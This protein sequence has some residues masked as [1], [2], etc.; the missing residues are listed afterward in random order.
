[1]CTDKAM[2]LVDLLQEN[3]VLRAEVASLAELLD[4]AQEIGEVPADW[5][6]LLKDARQTQKYLNI[7]EQYESL[8]KKLRDVSDKSE[9]E[10]LLEEVEPA[11]LIK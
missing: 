6:S 4:V 10:T 11:I 2:S 7:A 8:F 3:M 1:M 5:R 9:L